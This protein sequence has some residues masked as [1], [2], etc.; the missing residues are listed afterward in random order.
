MMSN[1]T[2]TTLPTSP[3]VRPGNLPSKPYTCYTYG[4]T[5]HISREYPNQVYPQGLHLSNN[6]ARMVVQY[7]MITEEPEEEDI[8]E[9]EQE[10]DI[11]DYQD[12]DN[13]VNI[14]KVWI[15]T[16]PVLDVSRKD[17]S[18][19]TLNRAQQPIIP[20]PIMIDNHPYIALVDCGALN[21]LIS[22]AILQDI[23]V[24]IIPQEGSIISYKG[25]QINWIGI[26]SPITLQCGTKTIQ[27]SFEITNLP[28]D[29]PVLIGLDLFSTLGFSIS[30]IP[31]DYL[32]AQVQPT[33]IT[34]DEPDPIISPNLTDDEQDKEF[35][36]A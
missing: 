12:I 4:K 17:N 28:E 2:F 15:S 29:T 11:Q 1:P 20:A 22:S 8:N 10:M 30:R 32:D 27:H 33:L 7:V 24:T 36:Q 21:T 18:I 35:K 25:Q 13:M 19:L 9:E 6:K 14:R 5:R 3:M 23:Q 31:V 34:S 26:M 16:L